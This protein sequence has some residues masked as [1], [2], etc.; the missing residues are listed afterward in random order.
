MAKEFTLYS[1]PTCP[2]CHKMRE[3]LTEHKVVFKEINLAENYDVAEQ[4]IKETNQAGVP[5]LKITENN[6]IKKIFVGY[7]TDALEEEFA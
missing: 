7:D 5:V 2:Y 4:M 3:W 6:K 1:T